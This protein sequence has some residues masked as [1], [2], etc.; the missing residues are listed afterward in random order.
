[1][2]QSTPSPAQ[3]RG[4]GQPVG[5]SAGSVILD[6]LVD[7]LD[8][9]DENSNAEMGKVVERLRA[10]AEMVGGMVAIHHTPKGNVQTPRGAAALRNG[11]DVSVIVSRNGNH[12]TLKHDKNRV[13]PGRSEWW[14]PGWTGVTAC[15]G[16]RPPQQPTGVG[17][18]P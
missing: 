14:L 6:N 8:G 9:V 16:S 12:L 4:R 7:F 11:V 17:K 15:S 3:R 10:I 2:E 13:G 5:R 1:V 18:T